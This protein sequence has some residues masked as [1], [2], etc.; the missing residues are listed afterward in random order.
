MREISIKDLITYRRKLDAG[1][2]KFVNDLNMN[3]EKKVNDDGGGGNYWICCTS[4]IVNCFKTNNLQF[5]IDKI[6]ELKYKLE[7]SDIDKTKI[8]YRRN[9]SILNNYEAF[10]FS[11]FKP[12]S[13][14]T[15][16]KKHKND[17]ILNVNGL[18]IKIT[19]DCVFSFVSNRNNEIGAIWF[20]AK[21]DGYNVDELGMFTDILFRYLNQ[22]YSKTHTIDPKYCIAV[23]IMKNNFV[24][25]SSIQ[26][27]EVP[28]ILDSTIA[29]INKFR[30]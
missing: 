27:L 14:L 15:F 3:F 10:D 26:N 11:D 18:Q 22:V 16:L 24:N 1:K 4:A 21:L 23:D 30:K 13:K 6:D 2:R 19:P 25:F 5:I 7:Q 17:S 28:A 29:E 8:M 9:I 20:I 12:I